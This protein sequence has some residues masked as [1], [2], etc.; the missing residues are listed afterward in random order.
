MQ[1]KLREYNMKKSFKN[2][3]VLFIPIWICIGAGIGVP[4]DNINIR[5]GFGA[6][7][8]IALFLKFQF[9]NKKKIR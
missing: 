7:I 4:L 5:V 6:L 2:T 8:G 3:P 1:I 9:R